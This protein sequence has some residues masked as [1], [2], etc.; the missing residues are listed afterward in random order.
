VGPTAYEP[1]STAAPTIAPTATVAAPAYRDDPLFWDQFGFDCRVSWGVSC[2]DLAIVTR[3]S[4]ADVRRIV[5]GC[6]RSCGACT[7][8]RTRVP[9]ARPSAAPRRRPSAALSVP[10]SGSPS[11]SAQPSGVPSAL[12]LDVPTYSVTV[13][14]RNPSAHLM[15]TP[16]CADDP[17]FRDHLGHLCGD[18]T[19]FNFSQPDIFG[20]GTN[21]LPVL[22]RW[23]PSTCGPCGVPSHLSLSLS[24]LEASD[25]Q[26]K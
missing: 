17:T 13:L 6:P 16:R 19:P 8:P 20:A 25:A 2:G 23:C 7:A 15:I 12:P 1:P 22:A 18:Y 5:A 4:D 3:Y 24:S 9:F 11:R 10:P 26:N 21:L 14:S